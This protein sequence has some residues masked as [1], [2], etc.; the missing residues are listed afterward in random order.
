MGR[1]W[2]HSPV[3][4]RLMPRLAATGESMSKFNESIRAVHSL[5][6]LRHLDTE[7]QQIG[8]VFTPLRAD[9]YPAGEK[10]PSSVPTPPGQ[11]HGEA[12]HWEAQVRLGGGKWGHAVG[13][14]Y[15]PENALESLRQGYTSAHR[16]VDQRRAGLMGRLGGADMREPVLGGEG[17]RLGFQAGRASEQ[18]NSVPKLEAVKRER[19]AQI[20]LLDEFMAKA[21]HQVSGGQA[22]AM[23][24]EKRAELG[25][26]P[27]VLTLAPA[28]AA[29]A[30]A[31]VTPPV[32]PGSR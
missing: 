32:A 27:F 13:T 4:Q 18:E 29:A 14:G 17:Y 11:E 12:C 15:T 16:E 3:A 28:T 25:L 1:E 30:A 23:F 7:P 21:Q 20:A 26:E 24:E 5:A 31:D 10:A 9:C 8:I 2:H 19:A 6:V 22:W